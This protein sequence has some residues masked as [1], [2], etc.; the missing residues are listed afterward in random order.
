[1]VHD[2]PRPAGN[3]D[4][5]KGGPPE[6][7][8]W[9]VVC[10]AGGKAALPGRRRHEMANTNTQTLTLKQAVESVPTASWSD[11]L[12]ELWTREDLVNGWTGERLAQPVTWGETEFG[13]PEIRSATSGKVLLTMVP[14]TGAD[15][16]SPPAVAP[17]ESE[18]R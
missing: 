8:A 15:I 2:R 3:P 12:G 17:S 1:M 5:R 10:T 14:P 16:S 7:G 13:R 11:P 9:H 6:T 18:A 4:G